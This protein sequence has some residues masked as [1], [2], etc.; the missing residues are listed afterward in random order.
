MIRYDYLW[1]NEAQA[2]RQEGA[3][4]RPCAVVVAITANPL[5]PRALVAAI[6]HSRPETGDAISIPPRVKKHLGLDDTPSWIITTE[7]NEIEWSDPGIVPVSNTQ[8]AYGHLPPVMAQALIDAI[9]KHL[10]TGPLPITK[11]K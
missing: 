4:I 7:V 1:R 11:R 3:K 5:Q 10:K 9:R 2:G 6:T 8:W